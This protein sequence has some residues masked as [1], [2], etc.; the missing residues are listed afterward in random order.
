MFKKYEIDR[1]IIKDTIAFGRRLGDDD[2]SSTAATKQQTRLPNSA[3][4]NQVER[5]EGPRGVQDGKC[6]L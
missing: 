3:E 5:H 4:N 6:I 1:Q 2:G